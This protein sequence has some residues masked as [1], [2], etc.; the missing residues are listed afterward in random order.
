MPLLGV[1]VGTGQQ[2]T[3]LRYLSLKLRNESRFDLLRRLDGALLR[4]YGFEHS[5]E[6][7]RVNM[8][9]AVVILMGAD[10][11]ILDRAPYRTL[12]YAALISSLLQ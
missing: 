9:R 11:A 1:A 8:D 4:L 12:C 7:G 2:L 5:E 3:Q 6:L 10:T